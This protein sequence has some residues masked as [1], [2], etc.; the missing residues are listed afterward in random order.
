MKPGLHR[1]SGMDRAAR[2]IGR[3]KRDDIPATIGGGPEPSRMS[4]YPG[5]GSWPPTYPTSAA[6]D[7]A[8]AITLL[9]WILWAIWPMAVDDTARYATREDPTRGGER[10]HPLA[11]EVGCQLRVARP[12]APF[13]KRRLHRRRSGRI[14]MTSGGLFG[15]EGGR[16]GFRVVVELAGVAWFGEF[17][18]L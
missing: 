4:E 12:L 15:T 10:H 13:R 18:G 7:T 1:L 8:A 9:A 5:R 11:A 16:V 2:L 3:L 6:T 17:V 14:V